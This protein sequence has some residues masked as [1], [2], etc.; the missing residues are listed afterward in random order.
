M[1]PLLLPADARTRH[2]RARALSTSQDLQISRLASRVMHLR[3]L[4]SKAFL[5]LAPLALPTAQRQQEEP[6]LLVL[7]VVVPGTTL[8]LLVVGY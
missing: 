7:L 1:P 8:L 2:A 5:A 6:I 4:R 3:V